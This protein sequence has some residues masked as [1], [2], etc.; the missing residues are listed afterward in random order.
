MK[1]VFVE[2]KY[3]GQIHLP[4]ELLK[5]LPKKI[6]LGFPVQF[7]DFSEKIKK[8]LE[9]AKKKVIHFSSRH[10]LYPG[11]LL[12]CDIHKFKG[13]YDAFL[14]V[15]DGKFHPTALLYEN[16]KPV[17]AYNPFTNSWDVWEKKDLLQLELKK[18]A[19]LTK[20]LHGENL[21]ILISVKPGQNK[22][23]LV[24][25]W[26]EKLEKKGKSVYLF[27][28]EEINPQTLE[29]FNFID[30]WINTACP[31]LVEDFNCLNL[32]DLPKQWF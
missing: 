8:Q 2:T 10:G 19:L 21:G 9:Q 11:Q 13:D 15:G 16:K 4:Q 27:I 29:N 1:K 22:I 28:S 32:E 7:L 31:R 12:G 25:K 18:K 20:L 30:V 26:K 14:Y 6:V 3:L 17:Y 23:K 24:D 5:I